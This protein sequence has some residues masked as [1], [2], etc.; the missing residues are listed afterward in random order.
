[1]TFHFFSKKPDFHFNLGANGH[2]RGNQSG[3]ASNGVS[4]SSSDCEFK[5]QFHL[6]ITGKKLHFNIK[7]HY[8]VAYNNNPPKDQKFNK[9]FNSI[10]DPKQVLSKQVLNA[11][12]QDLHAPIEVM[13]GA[14]LKSIDELQLM[15]S[16][17]QNTLKDIKILQGKKGLNNKALL[18]KLVDSLLETSPSEK[19][20]MTLLV[21]LQSKETSIIDKK[22]ALTSITT[23]LTDALVKTVRSLGQVFKRIL[24]DSDDN[25]I[26]DKLLAHFYPESQNSASSNAHHGLSPFPFGGMNQ[27]NMF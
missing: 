26:A 27:L 25:D 23:E 13:I 6:K 11:L 16:N 22:E 8:H 15:M 21:P 19:S 17:I 12:P 3:W 2:N 7:G 20:L 9:T 14:P 10:Y 24:S 5:Y 1:M 18:Q 4:N